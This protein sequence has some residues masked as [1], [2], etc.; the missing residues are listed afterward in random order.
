MKHQNHSLRYIDMHPAPIEKQPN[1]L[2]IVGAALL[3]WTVVY[4]AIV[5]LFTL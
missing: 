5:V 1:G 3:A 4:L 2:L